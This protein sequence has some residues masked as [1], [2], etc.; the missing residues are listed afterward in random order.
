MSRAPFQVLV[1]PF[2]RKRDGTL[3]YAVFKRADRQ[4]WQ[5]IAG[6]GENEESPIEAAR[7]EAWEEAG[8][9]LESAYLS[10]DSKC[11]VPVVGVTGEFTWGD[12]VFVIPERVFGVEVVNTD[13]RISGEHI[14]YRWACYDEAMSLLKWDSNRNAL[15]E[16]NE[17]IGRHLSQA[18]IAP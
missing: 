4:Y 17:R 8:I 16:L 3:E 13:L 11:T 14:Q 7:R 10:L 18:G 12:D 15:W 9:P 2:R 5:F 1:L 6:G